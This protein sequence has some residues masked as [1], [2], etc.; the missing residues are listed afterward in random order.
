MSLG[1]GLTFNP[2]PNPIHF[3]FQESRNQHGSKENWFMNP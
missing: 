3:F 2:T 1:V